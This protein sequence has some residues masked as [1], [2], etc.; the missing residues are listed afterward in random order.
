[1]AQIATDLKIVDGAYVGTM[2]SSFF[3][4]RTFGPGTPPIRPKKAEGTT[5]FWVKDGMLWKCEQQTSTDW[6]DGDEIE[7]TVTTEFKNFGTTKTNAPEEAL[8]LMEK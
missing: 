1:L 6:G 3:P 7:S 5:T 4:V 2:P 8:K